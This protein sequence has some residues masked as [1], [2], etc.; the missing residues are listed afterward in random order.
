MIVKKT[1]VI[2]FLYVNRVWL[3]RRPLPKRQAT[4]TVIVFVSASFD[5]ACRLHHFSAIPFAPMY[6]FEIFPL[7]NLWNDFKKFFFCYLRDYLIGGLYSL[8][9][10]LKHHG[11]D[12]VNDVLFSHFEYDVV[13][14]V[15][16]IF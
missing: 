13:F 11:N 15:T 4:R 2:P 3:K 14:I 12:G 5:Q 7:K 6:C 10:R 16:S 9:S 8:D 1:V